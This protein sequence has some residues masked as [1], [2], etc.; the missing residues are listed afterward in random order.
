MVQ[1]RINLEPGQHAFVERKMRELRAMAVLTGLED[2]V[3][4]SAVFQALV[5]MWK[6]LDQGEKLDEEFMDK[7]IGLK[8]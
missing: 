5:E 2:Q 3:T 7:K 4:V 8:T 6:A 1:L